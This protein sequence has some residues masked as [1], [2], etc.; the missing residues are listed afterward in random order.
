MHKVCPFCR[1]ASLIAWRLCHGGPGLLG[2][3]SGAQVIAR[4]DDGAGRGGGLPRETPNE[5]MERSR[6]PMSL[7]QAPR[8]L[9]RTRRGTPCQSPATPK[10]RCRMHGGAPGSGGPKGQRNGMWKHIRYS[11]EMIELRPLSQIRS[12]LIERRG[13]SS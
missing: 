11:Q 9:A 4:A 12:V 10:G 2:K 6:E 5:T 8:C 3:L 13:S 1:A 7:R